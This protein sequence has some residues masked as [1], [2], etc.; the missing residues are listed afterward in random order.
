LILLLISFLELFVFLCD[1]GDFTLNSS[2]V[3]I[4]LIN[5]LI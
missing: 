1:F 4:K 3:L 2:Q 5:L